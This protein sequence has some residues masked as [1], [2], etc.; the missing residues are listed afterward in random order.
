MSKHHELKTWKNYFEEVVR[1]NKRFEIRDDS[2]RAFQKGDTI[3]LIETE[4][5]Q[6][7]SDVPTGRTF[8]GQITFVTGFN[9]FDGNVVFGFKQVPKSTI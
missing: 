7:A 8:Y 9:Q 2:D 3:T 6:L 4:K 1:G 5:K